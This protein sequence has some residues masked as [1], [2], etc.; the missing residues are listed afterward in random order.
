[1][2]AKMYC[3]DDRPPNSNECSFNSR[4]MSNIVAKVKCS[5]FI[6]QVCIGA[7]DDDEFNCLSEKSKKAG[8]I[9]IGL[10]INTSV[11]ECWPELDLEDILIFAKTY[12]NGIYERISKEVEPYKHT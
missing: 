10:E 11:A 8:R 1:M 12:C 2:K 7:D 3:D 9:K 4:K 5:P 6:D